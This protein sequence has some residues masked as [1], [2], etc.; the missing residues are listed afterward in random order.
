MGDRGRGDPRLGV[1]RGEERNRGKPK[2]DVVVFCLRLK[3]I[4]EY[5]VSFDQYYY[6]LQGILFR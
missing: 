6:T 1:P 5:V 2:D 3:D 4:L